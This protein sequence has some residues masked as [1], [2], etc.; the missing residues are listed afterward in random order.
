MQE[1]RLTTLGPVTMETV[2][3]AI[4]L[5]VLADVNGRIASL[6]GHC[7]PISLNGISLQSS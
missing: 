2:Q 5:F 4:M 3:N 1:Y 7:T 6:A